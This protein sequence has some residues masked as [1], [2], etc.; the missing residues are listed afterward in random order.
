M[1]RDE[2]NR[3][4]EAHAIVLETNLQ[5]RCLY[6]TYSSP[7]F[8]NPIRR[9]GPTADPVT[10]AFYE[11]EAV[12]Q[13]RAE[14]IHTW[15]EMELKMRE[16]NDIELEC[17]IRWRMLGKSFNEIGRMVGRS[18]ESLRKKLDRHFEKTTQTQNV[19]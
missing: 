3:L 12:Q 4:L 19:Q 16:M 5:L 11:I 10:K 17:I 13:R 18:G 2:Y 9:D 8:T 15:R 6:D 1:T 14:A 7:K